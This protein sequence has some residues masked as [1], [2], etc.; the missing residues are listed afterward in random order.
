LS[1]KYERKIKLDKHIN[2]KKRK[3]RADM[4]SPSGTEKDDTPQ[5]RARRVGNDEAHDLQQATMVERETASTSI[6]HKEDGKSSSHASQDDLHSK[7]K[8][9]RI[10][11]ENRTPAVDKNQ[12]KDITKVEESDISQKAAADM[13]VRQIKDQV[14]HA[15]KIGTEAWEWGESSVATRYSVW[16]FDKI[17]F[18]DLG[19]SGCLKN[20][21]EIQQRLL[22]EGIPSLSNRKI[23]VN[24]LFKQKQRSQQK[25]RFRYGQELDDFDLEFSCDDLQHVEKVSA[26]NWKEYKEKMM[27]SMERNDF[28]SPVEHLWTDEVVPLVRPDE[29]LNTGKLFLYAH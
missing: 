5:K 28:V 24:L 7:K 13:G 1:T 12:R 16:D 10:D 19:D 6:L 21:G 29:A 4:Q 2:L 25:S 8:I 11:S 27:E 17:T 18:P 3:K 20:K 9:P 15:G 26:S 22:P 23:D 14:V